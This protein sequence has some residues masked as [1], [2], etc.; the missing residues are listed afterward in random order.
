MRNLHLSVP[1]SAIFALSIIDA[2]AEDQTE[3]VCN[4]TCERCSLRIACLIVFAMP[5]SLA[6][7][8]NILTMSRSHEQ[9]CSSLC[10]VLENPV[11]G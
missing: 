10:D 2:S 8:A 9:D 6:Q 11:Y 3:L 4:G 1:T 7:H 5:C